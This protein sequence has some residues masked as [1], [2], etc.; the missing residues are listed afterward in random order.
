MSIYR[1]NKSKSGGIA[2]EKYIEYCIRCMHLPA[3]T[4]RVLSIVK[5]T[6]AAC[7]HGTVNN[8]FKKNILDLHYQHDSDRPVQLHYSGLY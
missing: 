3:E 5:N 6:I 1:E 8:C 4:V 7:I 2:R